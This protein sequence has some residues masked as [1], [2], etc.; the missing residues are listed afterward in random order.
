MLI[1][2]GNHWLLFNITV[3]SRLDISLKVLAWGKVADLVRSHG[4]HMRFQWEEDAMLANDSIAAFKIR[5]SLSTEGIAIV[6]H[7]H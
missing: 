6:V 3:G 7:S 5:T 1:T 4:Q 2:K